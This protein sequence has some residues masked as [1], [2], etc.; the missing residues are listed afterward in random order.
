MKILLVSYQ[1][2]LGENASLF[3]GVAELDHLLLLGGDHRG[4]LTRPSHPDPKM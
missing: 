1:L 4:L 3:E 2:T